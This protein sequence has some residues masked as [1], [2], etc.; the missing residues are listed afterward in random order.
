MFDSLPEALVKIKINTKTYG[1]RRDREM[2]TTRIPLSTLA[3]TGWE[4]EQS[5]S[6]APKIDRFP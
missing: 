6:N 1:G 3:A 2:E 4:G 5:G